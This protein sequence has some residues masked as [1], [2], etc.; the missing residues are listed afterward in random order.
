[1]ARSFGCRGMVL[2]EQLLAL[3]L[4]ALLLGGLAQG[5]LALSRTLELQR[6]LLLTGQQLLNTAEQLR[7][8]QMG[9]GQSGWQW[10]AATGWQV[11]VAA[12]APL[13]E[14]QLGLWLVMADGPPQPLQLS[15]WLPR[16]ASIPLA[17]AA[18]LVAPE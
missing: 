6:Q 1:M 10:Q 5:Y 13:L 3:L 7:L 17:L 12:S 9:A 8:P 18:T 14:Q 15:L 2:L 16:H 11:Q 4:L